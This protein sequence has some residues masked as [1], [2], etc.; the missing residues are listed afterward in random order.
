MVA[1]AT[2]RTDRSWCGG[3]MAKARILLAHGNADCQTIYGSVLRHDGYDVDV[4]SDVESALVRLARVSYD[5]VVADLYLESS[6]DEC[7]LRRMRHAPFAAHLPVV[8]LTGWSSDSHRQ[9]AMDEDADEFLPLPTRP[10][11]L[12]DRVDAIIGQPRRETRAAE[13]ASRD[14]DRPIANGI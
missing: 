2:R 12:V 10:R 4:A 8:V 13:R 1:H 9:L 14:K 6:A 11:E 3:A 5:L 7:L